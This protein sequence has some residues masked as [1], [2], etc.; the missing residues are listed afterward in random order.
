MAVRAVQNHSEICPFRRQTLFFG[1][2]SSTKERL[3]WPRLKNVWSLARRKEFGAEESGV[4]VKSS[5]FGPVARVF[6]DR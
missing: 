1:R 3:L 5:D 6:H 4:V 2:L